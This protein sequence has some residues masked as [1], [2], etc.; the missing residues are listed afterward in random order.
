[1]SVMQDDYMS[2]ENTYLILG[3]FHC[4]GLIASSELGFDFYHLP[5]ALQFI[6]ILF[7]ATTVFVMLDLTPNKT[8]FY[9]LQMHCKT[10]LNVGNATIS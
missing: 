1:M 2:K 9:L 10:Y 6:H 5:L 3:C 4:L 7:W 8:T